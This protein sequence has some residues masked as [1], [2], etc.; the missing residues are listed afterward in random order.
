MRLCNSVSSF[1][2]ERAKKAFKTNLFMYMDG[3][4]LLLLLTFNISIKVQLPF[5]KT[6]DDKC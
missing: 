3:K 4:K 5:V 6:L 2:V 1:E